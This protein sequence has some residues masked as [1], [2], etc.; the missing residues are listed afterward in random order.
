MYK[1]T[2]LLSSRPNDN[3][4][5]LI[6]MVRYVDLNNPE[7]YGIMF[8]SQSLD[9]KLEKSSFFAQ[10]KNEFVLLDKKTIEKEFGVKLDFNVTS[11]GVV[12]KI[13]ARLEG[14]K[15]FLYDDSFLTSAKKRI[16]L[17]DT[18]IDKEVENKMNGYLYNLG[19]LIESSSF[20][21]SEFDLQDFESYVRGIKEATSG[22][23]AFSKSLPADM[24]VSNEGGSN[25]IEGCVDTLFGV[26]DTLELT[27]H[28]LGEKYRDRLI[29]QLEKRKK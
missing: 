13:Y 11:G 8:I 20:T 3:Y 27:S 22:I 16:F 19:N 14:E 5:G 7:D 1:I 15:S 23:D 17:P 9:N 12:S 29:R 6:H 4:T 26:L 10:K 28:N 21:S 18:Q 24:I 2:K 25:V